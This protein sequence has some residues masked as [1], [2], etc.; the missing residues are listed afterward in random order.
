MGDLIVLRIG[1]F[2]LTNI[3]VL[4]VAGVVLSLLGVGSYR[5]ADGL[6]LQSLLIFCAVFGFTGS[7]ISLFLSKWMAKKTM[8]VQLIDHPRN[9]DEQ[10]LVDTVVELSQ[11]A[12]IK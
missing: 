7:F 9:A 4:V 12:G 2:L 6:N 1:L 10:W 3:A 8:G 5:S 11:K